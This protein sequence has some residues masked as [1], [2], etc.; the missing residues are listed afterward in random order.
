MRAPSELINSQSLED[1]KVRYTL[2]KCNLGKCTLKKYMYIFPKSIAVIIHF[3]TLLPPYTR[4]A[5]RPTYT[6]RS[7]YAFLQ[8]QISV[9]IPLRPSVCVFEEHCCHH[10]F[11]SIAA[12]IQP[13]PR[14]IQASIHPWL[15]SSHH[16]DQMSQMSWSRWDF[17]MFKLLWVSFCRAGKMA[18]S[19]H[20]F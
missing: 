9:C 11:P 20:F 16:S 7:I 2:Q 13:S 18:I 10:I 8:P 1:T 17:T 4:E 6:P 15:I 5:F 19:R 3:W 12:S 14:S